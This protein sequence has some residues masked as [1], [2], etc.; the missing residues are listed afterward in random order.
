MNKHD[1]AIRVEGMPESYLR[2]IASTTK[3]TA[4]WVWVLD[5]G[6]IRSCLL[7]AREARHGDLGCLSGRHAG[8]LPDVIA[9][10]H[11]TPTTNICVDIKRRKGRYIAVPSWSNGV[12]CDTL[13]RAQARA[14]QMAEDYE[15]I[16][17]S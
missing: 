8:L 1:G 2:D 7:D 9:R 16:L 12:E 3:A 6:A 14:E 17:N 13:Q 10:Y 4:S 11:R 15:R 5:G